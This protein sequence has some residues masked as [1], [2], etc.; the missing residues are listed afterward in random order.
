VGVLLYLG[1]WVVIPDEVD[2]ASIAETMV[3][4]RRS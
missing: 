3:N 4:K 2:G 1:A